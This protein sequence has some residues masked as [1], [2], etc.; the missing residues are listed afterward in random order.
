MSAKKPEKPFLQAPTLP[1]PLEDAVFSDECAQAQT[2]DLPVRGRRFSGEDGLFPK[3]QGLSFEGCAFEGLRFRGGALT[4]CFF[5]DVVFHKCDLSNIDF[6]NS[7]F[8]KARFSDCKMVG[9]SFLEGTLMDTGFYRDKCS[10]AQLLSARL[11]RVE[12]VESDFSG[13][14]MQEMKHTYLRLDGCRFIGAELFRT[15]LAGVDFT[16]SDIDGIIV[17]IPDLRGA[18]VTALQACELARLMGLII[19]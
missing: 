9:T 2:D 11:K 3:E 19:E 13:A 8:H 1:E 6:S 18:K 12:L 7:V 15:P 10:C 5:T 16:T 14:V 17:S 4:G